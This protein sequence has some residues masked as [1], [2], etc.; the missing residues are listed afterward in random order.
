MLLL[1]ALLL[2][3]DLAMP[4]ATDKA[5]VRVLIPTTVGVVEVLLLTEE[6]PALGR[7]VACIGG[8]TEVADIDAGYDAFVARPTGVVER[9]FGH[10]CYRLDLSGP[11][12]AGSSWQLGVLAA[13]ALHAAGRLAQEGEAAECVIWATGTV[14]SVDLSV[15]AVSH[16]GEKVALS[17]DRLRQEVE[18]GQRVMVVLPAQ[19]AAD[20]SPQL[21]DGLAALGVELVE[22]D[23]LGPL[24]EWLG[25]AQ[26]AADARDAST[27]RAAGR[28]GQVRRHPVGDAWLRLPW[29]A[30]AVLLLLL[31]AAGALGPWWASNEPEVAYYRALAWRRG[32]P[33]GVGRIDAGTRAH[34]AGVYRISRRRGRVVEVRCENSAGALL[35]DVDGQARWVVHYRESGVAEK[36][37]VFRRNGRLVREER[38]E[39]AGG[40]KLIVQFMHSSVP[41]AQAAVQPMALDP[42]GKRERPEGRT[43][44]TRHELT[45]DADGLVREL[46]YQNPWGTPA[47]NGQGS[48]GQHLTHTPSGLE[49]RRAEI[50]PDGAE[51]TLNSGIRAVFSVYDRQD[52]LVRHTLIGADGRPFDGPDWYAFYEVEYDGRGNHAAI[53]YFGSD[54]K[55]ALRRDGFATALLRHDAH[56]NAVEEA[57]LGVDGRPA[58]HEN[59]YARMVR[60]YDARGSV[61]EHAFL[62][63]EGRPTLHRRGFAKDARRYDARGN[64]AEIAYF[65]VDGTPTLIEDGY[66]KVIYGYDDSSNLTGVEYFDV[67][68]LPTANNAGIAKIAQT[69]DARGKLVSTEYFA[70]DGKLTIGKDG[71]ARCARVYDERGNLTETAYL[72]T[73]GEPALHKDGYSKQTRR[74]DDRGNLAE[75]AY[76]GVDGRST[77]VRG[78]ARFTRRYDT[79]GNMVEERYF[80]VDGAPTLH[81]DGY[82][83]FTQ[84]LDARG[85]VTE[86]ALFGV[87]DRLRANK[88]GIAKIVSRYDARDNLIESTNFGID[89]KPAANMDGIATFRW[90]Y[91]ARGNRTGAA[92]FGVDGMPTAGAGGVASS[93]QIYDAR[94]KLLEITLYGADGKLLPDGVA[95]ATWD[96]DAR[97]RVSAQ[98]YFGGDGLPTLHRDGMAKSIYVYDARGNTIELSYLGIDGRPILDWLGMAKMT[99]AYDV[100]GK[101]IEE[102]Y[103]GVDGAPTLQAGGYARLTTAYDARGNVLE[104]RYFGLD[105]GPA[106]RLPEGLAARTRFVRDPR[107]RLITVEYFGVDDRRVAIEAAVA[108]V[109]PGSLA[110]KIGFRAGDRLVAYRGE[111]VTSRE[112][113]EYLRALPTAGDTAI[114]VLRGTERLDLV[115]PANRPLGLQLRNVAAQPLSARR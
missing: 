105:G 43:D 42:F 1:G 50:G 95:K 81:D 26:L 52:R 53:R 3:P 110:D 97:G 34:L 31:L 37:E 23:T 107:G 5:K 90:T 45:L 115:A 22:A 32:L 74:Y 78:V 8:T 16:L 83:K 89:G 100:R 39:K 109:A 106:L 40:D 38:L 71:C 35:D 19:D 10:R 96:Y 92:A 85:N 94:G 29:V 66:A 68:G 69:F 70:V 64:L 33:D 79:R 77:L 111:K 51:I 11:I 108:R 88:D 41:Q 4:M 18:G 57:Y 24:W 7:S 58:L 73:D 9:L 2:P 15:G 63:T 20:L 59:G 84:V 87:D 62:D 14:R 13:H 56:G 28:A 48:F 76:F 55:P 27:G 101:A 21:G 30:G 65:G 67:D 93:T 61:I 6:D 98:A 104:Q 112:H 60:A 103:F 36:L 102:R 49:Q 72:G 91:D 82:A 17:L 47:K 75:V 54:G 46:R 113:L 44:I 99:V 80:G 12:D 25:L 114:R 86:T